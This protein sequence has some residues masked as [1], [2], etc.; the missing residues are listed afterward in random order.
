MIELKNNQTINAEVLKKLLLSR[1]TTTHR[2]KIL[3]THEQMC[4]A[5]MG[6]YMA[7]VEY[8]KMKYKDDEETK[9]HISQVAKWLVDDDRKFGLMLCGYC[10]TGK[11]TVI[12]AIRSLL[13]WMYAQEPIES[14]I[15]LKIINAQ[16]VVSLA[17]YKQDEYKKLFH[18]PFL[19]I[20]ELGIEPSEALDYGNVICPTIELLSR[21]YD[22]C[23]PTIVTT[24]L[25]PK[26]IS[27]HYDE[28]IA[29]RFR[30]MMQVVQFIN[31]TY[32]NQ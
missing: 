20:D 28:R 27:K 32:R 16:E 26:D 12:Y 17:K 21:R 6:A 11:T 2:F 4:D 22:G 10:G 30:E 3:F 29:D 5:L 31:K 14:S 23:L 15:V 1:K 19:A 13:Q 24:N 8:R 7:E 9:K 25:E 18:I